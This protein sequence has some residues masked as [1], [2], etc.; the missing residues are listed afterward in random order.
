ML[1][2]LADTHAE[3]TAQLTDHLRAVVA[4]A[5]VVVHA[6]DFTTGAVL[7]AFESAT[8]RFVAVAGNSDTAAVRQRLPDTRAVDWRERR[9]VLAHG[10]RHDRTALSLLARQE[11]AD[12]AV[13]GHTHAA[14]IDRVGKTVV[15]N[16]GS[17]ADPRGN[18]PTYA[19]CRDQA[20][21]V[22]VQIR[23][24]SGG[25]VDAVRV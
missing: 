9:F 19:A 25:V 17:H 18:R 6:G 21:G 22:N 20:G 8:D 23:T 11:S 13:V 7:D 24:V 15:V 4:D 3:E 16:P 5:S 12:V 10:H 1:V 2:A 14:G